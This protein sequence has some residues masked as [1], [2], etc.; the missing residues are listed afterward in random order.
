MATSLKLGDRLKIIK[1]GVA[2]GQTP[3][4][5]M[6]QYKVNQNGGF[7]TWKNKFKQVTGIDPDADNTYDY[8]KFFKENPEAANQIIEGKVSPEILQMYKTPQAIEKEK[9]IQRQKRSGSINSL[10]D[11]SQYE[12]IINDYMNKSATQLLSQGG[13][14]N[15]Q[16]NLFAKG[17]KADDEEMTYNDKARTLNSMNTTATRFGF[18]SP[19]T[20]EVAQDFID[21]AQKFTLDNTE[22]GYKNPEAYRGLEPIMF[23]KV[24][25]TFL[26]E[27]YPNQHNISNATV[28]Y[29]YLSDL[30]NSQEGEPI[31]LHAVTRDTKEGK[32]YEY[33]LKN[34]TDIQ[35]WRADDPL[36]L[37]DYHDENVTPETQYILND[38][39]IVTPES[40]IEEEI[41]PEIPK[42][43]TSHPYINKP[44]EQNEPPLYPTSTPTTIPKDTNGV[45]WGSEQGTGTIGIG[46]DEFN[47]QPYIYTADDFLDPSWFQLQQFGGIDWQPTPIQY[48]DPPGYVKV[49]NYDVS[50]VED[51]FDGIDFKK[52]V[53]NIAGYRDDGLR[54]K[55]MA[56][57][58][59]PKNYFADPYAG[60][61]YTNTTQGNAGFDNDPYTKIQRESNGTPLYAN[62]GL[63]N[64]FQDG[65]QIYNPSNYNGLT[66]L[67]N[68]INTWTQGAKYYKNN[69][70]YDQDSGRLVFKDLGKAYQPAYNINGLNIYSIPASD[71]Q[72]HLDKVPEGQQYST[73]LW[74]T[75][76]FNAN[77]NYLAV[78]NPIAG[79]AYSLIPKNGAI[80]QLYDYYKDS[81]ISPRNTTEKFAANANQQLNNY[82][83]DVEVRA[84]KS[85]DNY[86][87]WMLSQGYMPWEI[88]APD[89]DYYKYINDGVGDVK[90]LRA[91]Y[92]NMYFLQDYTAQYPQNQLFDADKVDLAKTQ[93]AFYRDA[94][95]NIGV[96]WG[97]NLNPYSQQDL[98]QNA[99]QS[100]GMSN[101]I[102]Y[103]FPLNGLGAPSMA[104]A[105]ATTA[106]STILPQ[107]TSPIGK[108]LLPK[109]WNNENAETIGE[110]GGGLLGGIAG[111]KAGRFAFNNY[112]LEGMLNKAM[113]EALNTNTSSMLP[114]RTT[115][116]RPYNYY[117]V[118]NPNVGERYISPAPKGLWAGY[119]K[120]YFKPGDIPTPEGTA[121]RGVGVNDHSP[122]AARAAAK[123]AVNDA[124]ETGRVRSKTF[125][126]PHFQLPNTV[127]E[128]TPNGEITTSG[129]A[130]AGE[131]NVGQGYYFQTKPG[132]WL[133]NVD[134][135]G[136]PMGYKGFDQSMYIPGEVTPVD[137][138][139][140]NFYLYKPVF[141]NGLKYGWIRQDMGKPLNV[142]GYFSN[143]FD[144]AISNRQ[145]LFNRRFNYN[146][147]NNSSILGNANSTYKDLT[148][149]S[150]Y[151]QA[152]QDG[153]RTG[154]AKLVRGEK[155]NDS[156]K[157]WLDNTEGNINI[158]NIPP[159]VQNIFNAQVISRTPRELVT[160]HVPKIGRVSRMNSYL[161]KQN[162]I[163]YDD[164]QNFLKNGNYAAIDQ[165]VMDEVMGK[166][167]G[168]YYDTNSGSVVISNADKAYRIPIML[169]EFRH[170]YDDLFVLPESQ[171]QIL[172]QAYPENWETF[173]RTLP[174]DDP[175]RNYT[176]MNMERVTTNADAR[177]QLLGESNLLKS[178]EE[179][180]KIIDNA[181]SNDIINALRNSNGYGSRYV[182][183][184]E[185][186]YNGNIPPEVTENLRKA[187]KYVGI[188]TGVGFM[189]KTLNG[190]S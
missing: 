158:E 165:S 56:E 109:V 114:Y 174:A 124:V 104:A 85:R 169:H 87:N 81:P 78:Q 83:Q 127:E 135:N 115:G 13:Y 45:P 53:L 133:N 17:G 61:Y 99:T 188:S 90:A 166:N 153:L 74:G 106:G 14:V 95:A 131:S 140:A 175:L 55:L 102:P 144:N 51:D 79:N 149:F 27:Y 178:L 88:N 72:P 30:Q 65:S 111:F 91:E 96:D 159:E 132:V 180:N 94:A 185:K 105:I 126:N 123:A 2:K 171:R 84:Q 110:I 139:I 60:Q 41:E 146:G 19:D 172:M 134:M 8:E 1:D 54:D 117:N 20:I 50:Q 57:L 76:G 24:P 157:M 16:I 26:D 82:L 35:R 67:V 70:A 101:L 25:R 92:P 148:P 151:I 37:R 4:E 97:N 71:I 18:H 177:R 119:N 29:I 142:K 163:K 40:Y 190:N 31:T 89:V 11:Y 38:E 9:Q 141:R 69:N 75:K 6:I 125:N 161:T 7:P 80:S 121:L 23:I 118:F 176:H 170:K 130:F 152:K 136:N 58:L 184:L 32:A 68:N 122:K 98:I 48:L 116:I 86:T 150:D 108:W 21:T 52:F 129:N 112:S 182:S 162:E 33:N 3:Q 113:N 28:Y 5:A 128:I 155:L 187:M 186:L 167:F 36:G 77:Q 173:I 120:R 154:I 44:E 156:D 62:G 22:F 103:T 34:A 46:D 93:Q 138:S 183:Y 15:K 64:L 39:V 66:D 73:G 47:Q 160:Q 147:K 145:N 164:F 107:I 179:Q 59:S 12:K 100:F 168:G 63:V 10:M 189:G 49:P 143:M 137:K 42:Q 43:Q 181:S